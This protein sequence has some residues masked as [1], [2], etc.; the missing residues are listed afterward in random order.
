LIGKSLTSKLK[1]VGGCVPNDEN[2]MIDEIEQRKQ[3]AAKAG[4]DNPFCA[5]CANMTR[6]DSK[7]CKR[8]ID[9]TPAFNVAVREFLTVMEGTKQ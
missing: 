4:Y 2:E 3:E 6:P 9:D 7:T 1:G 5:S 8:C